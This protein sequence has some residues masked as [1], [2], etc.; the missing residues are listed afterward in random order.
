MGRSVTKTAEY[1]FVLETSHQSAVGQKGE[2]MTPEQLGAEWIAYATRLDVRDVL[3]LGLTAHQL[4]TLGA[5]LASNTRLNLLAPPPPSRR[6]KKTAQVACQCGCGTVFTAEYVTKKPQYLNA[7][8]RQ[9]AYRRRRA[10]R[11]WAAV[12]ASRPRAAAL[13]RKPGGGF[14]VLHQA[15]GLARAE[16]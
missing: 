12:E 14:K 6:Q 15:I 7:A 3:A 8:H 2:I 10:D 1:V 9:R 5:A 4:T 11:H 16:G 13:E